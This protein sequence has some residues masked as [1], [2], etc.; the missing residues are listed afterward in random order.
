MRKGRFMLR[1]LFIHSVVQKQLIKT[2]KGLC[3]WI[4]QAYATGRA[5]S[6]KFCRMI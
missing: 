4:S 6:L 2:I 5:Y 3:D 1:Y